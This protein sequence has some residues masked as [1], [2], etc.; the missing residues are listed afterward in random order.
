MADSFRSRRLFLLNLP[1]L[2]CF[3]N[4]RFDG[5]VSRRSDPLPTAPALCSSLARI[6]EGRES[7][8][9]YEGADVYSETSVDDE[10]LGKPDAAVPP[11]LASA[12]G[13]DSLD[14]S[15]LG[16]FQQISR[17]FDLSFLSSALPRWYNNRCSHRRHSRG[18]S[19]CV[20]HRSLPRSLLLTQR[21]SLGFVAFSALHSFRSSYVASVYDCSPAA[22][23][24]RRRLERFVLWKASVLYSR[25][26]RLKEGEE[27]CPT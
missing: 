14:I 21:S 17:V 8:H 4:G 13:A 11:A 12:N 7:Q 5:P 23:A 22:L 9:A 18:A 27:E 1:N 26:S 10:A 2:R 15:S 24:G 3:S 19:R 6:S 16:H 20:H 25:S